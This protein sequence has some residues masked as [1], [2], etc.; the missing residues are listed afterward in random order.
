MK[1]CLNPLQIKFFLAGKIIETTV[2]HNN[3]CEMSI[4]KIF[5][6]A[7]HEGDW[8]SRSRTPLILTSAVI[9]TGQVH[10]LAI[11]SSEKKSPV[12]IE[13]GA[14]L[15][16]SVSVDAIKKRKISLP[17]RESSQDPSTP[18]IW[19]STILRTLDL[20][21]IVQSKWTNCQRVG[22][23]IVVGLADRRHRQNYT[24]VLSWRKLEG[25]TQFH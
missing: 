10:G 14:G 5:S 15:G 12:T 2:Y 4:N 19:S 6:Y 17:C 18:N 22:R 25:S 21:V 8:G 24:S 16:A 13:Q 9:A 20:N 1:K 7:S 3:T 11:L 23:E